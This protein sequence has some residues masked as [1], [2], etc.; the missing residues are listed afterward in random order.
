LRF[1]KLHQ[2][3]LVKLIVVVRLSKVLKPVTVTE[4]NGKSKL[5]TTR[6]SMMLRVERRWRMNVGDPNAVENQP[7]ARESDML[8]LV[9][10]PEKVKAGGAKEH[11]C[12]INFSITN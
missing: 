9:K 5:R 3:S 1:N 2:L 8:I 11:Y 7:Q 12:I 6:G 10:K 4:D